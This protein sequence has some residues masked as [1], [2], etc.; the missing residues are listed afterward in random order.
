KT[1]LLERYGIDNVVIVPF[2]IEFSQQQPDEYIEKFLLEKFSPRYIVIGY[3][4]RFGLNRQGDVNFLKWYAE[5]GGYEVIEIAP[6]EVDSIAVS[7]TKIRVALEAGNIRNANS[8]LLHNFTLSGKVV[9]G[10]RIGHTIG[11]PTANIEISDSH[12]LIPPN[13]IYAAYAKLA[14]TEEQPEPRRYEAMLYIGNRPTLPELKNRTIEVNIFD[15]NEDIYGKELIVELVAFIRNDAKME[16]LEAL[17]NQ[18]AKDKIAALQTLKKKDPSAGTKAKL[19]NESKAAVVILNYNGKKYL[20][21]FL[22]NIIDNTGPQY[23]IYVADNGSTDDSLDY[24]QQYFPEVPVIPLNSNSGF[25][26]GY[27]LALEKVQSPYFVLL[28]SDIETT[29]NWLD[30]LIELMEQDNSIG[31]CQP[32]ILA[33]HNKTHFEYAGAAG[34]WLDYLG[35]P[36]CRGRI[37]DVNEEDK[38]QY[39]TRQEIFWA[40]GA[41]LVIRGELFKKI[42]GFDGSYFAH[43]EEIDLCWRVKRAGYKIVAEPKSVVYHVG[44]GTLDYLS[45]QKTYLNFRNSLYTIIKNEPVAKLWW[46]I[47]L[48]LV[49]DGVAGALFLTQGKFKHI[50]S[51]LRAHGSLYASL[52]DLRKRRNH[53]AQLVKAEAISDKT[54]TMGMYRGS[55]VWQFYIK[56]K[57]YFSELK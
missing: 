10:Q 28:N 31:A 16:S 42:G 19:T 54:N 38:G 35:Y 5:K 9:R 1:A 22:R 17:Q 57:R 23:Q 32:K 41:A 21:Q 52:V 27:N 30:P 48:R 24:L 44:G 37:F 34:G 47:P 43:S 3:D 50:W 4:H 11:F 12:K 56:G 20:Q 40:T 25:A 36:F 53:F 7:S 13:G 55:V 15:F 29:P 51:I 18:L 39:D 46:L 45:P 14:R 6:Q 26:Q 33:Y 2:T 49:L 8:L